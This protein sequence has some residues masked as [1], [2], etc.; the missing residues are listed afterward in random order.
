MFSVPFVS[1][2]VV[3]T[4]QTPTFSVYSFPLF[5]VEHHFIGDFSLLL[6]VCCVSFVS[7]MISLES[8]AASQFSCIWN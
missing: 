1:Q 4:S 3:F 6:V 5:F 8:E 7:I 2:P